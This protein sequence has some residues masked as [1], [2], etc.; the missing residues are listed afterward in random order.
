M[1]HGGQFVYFGHVEKMSFFFMIIQLFLGKI[2][3]RIIY[4]HP[5][6]LDMLAPKSS[7]ISSLMIRKLL[8]PRNS[9]GKDAGLHFLLRVT[10]KL[11]P[12]S[13]ILVQ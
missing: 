3:V 5:L 13:S 6:P 7:T 4:P 8:C 1:C 12:I 11:K 9:D 2:K 10:L